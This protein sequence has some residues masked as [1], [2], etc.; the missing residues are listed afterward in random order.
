LP[1]LSLFI[2]VQQLNIFV[3]LFGLSLSLCLQI[4]SRT[5]DFVCLFFCYKM[6]FSILSARV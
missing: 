2:S 1:K 5:A 4:H 6:Y 3:K